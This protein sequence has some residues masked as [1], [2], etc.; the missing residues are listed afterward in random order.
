MTET[1]SEHQS[2]IK[3]TFRYQ[4]YERE[5]ILPKQCTIKDIRKSLEKQIKISVKQMKMIYQNNN[6]LNQPEKTKAYNYFG[7][8]KEIELEME[9]K[10]FVEDDYISAFE[11]AFIGVS[12]PDNDGSN[13]EEKKRKLLHLKSLKQEKIY[14]PQ[15]KDRPVCNYDGTNEASYVCLNCL[16]Y[17]CEHCIKFEVHQNELCEI[18]KLD[19][20]LKYKRGVLLKELEEKVTGDQHF[21]KLEKI[22]FLLNEKVSVIDKQFSEMM[23][24][25]ERIKEAQMKFVIDYFYQKLNE[26]KYKTLNRDSNFFV[27]QMKDL[28]LNY[29]SNNIEENI[30]NMQ[31]MKEGLDIIIKKFNDFIVRYDDFDNL[32][33]EYDNFNQAFKTQLEA[34]IFQNANVGR[35]IANPEELKEKVELKNQI[36]S[37][38]KSKKKPTSLIKIKYYNSIMIW[39]HINQKLIRVSD[40]VDKNEFKLNYQVYAGNIFLNL[41]NKLF[42]I[43]GGNFNMF[44]YYEPLRNEIFRLP[45]LQDNHCR[46]GMIYIK[47]LNAIFCIS[48]KYTKKVEIFG[49]KYLKVSNEE[50]GIK[51]DRKLEKG[52]SR[53]ES[54]N[55]L[56][57]RKSSKKVTRKNSRKDLKKKTDRVDSSR[58][59]SSSN[60]KK[61]F[62]R[63]KTLMSR[64]SSKN[65]KMESSASIKKLNLDKINFM[66]NENLKWEE[67]SSLNIA[68]NYACFA[69]HN[70]SYLYVFFGYNQIRG[71]LDSIEK[72]NLDES[73]EFE[74]IKYHNPKNLDLHRNSMSCCF[75][76]D[77]EIYILGGTIRDKPTDQILKYNFKHE[78]F[79]KTEMTING[80]H[81]NEYFRFWEESSFIP[82]SSQGYSINSDDDFTFGLIDA[83]DKVHLFNIRS[84]KYN[85]I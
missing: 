71:Y 72:I 30:K 31:T 19:N 12:K 48:G 73:L 9:F 66:D 44:Y 46:G 16:Q 24:I 29:N 5:S 65:S 25:L 28:E 79:Y 75:A 7:D 68:R 82:L 58:S 70:E 34:K 33:N 38:I 21:E 54:R 18:R 4:K 55:E 26:K 11:K 57:S 14:E 41:K 10:D 53:K 69:I 84:F 15:F 36:E 62:K 32:F 45:N 51:S 23:G 61:T 37:K 50:D 2:Q 67:F 52:I 6:I 39:N 43:T 64:S 81:E 63:S 40:F 74:L 20:N 59:R 35:E 80:L 42:I 49:M 56:L 83:R 17:W 78:T 8:V 77:D 3:V 27:N 85:I 1:E 47:K 60:T 76:N 22:D 13:K